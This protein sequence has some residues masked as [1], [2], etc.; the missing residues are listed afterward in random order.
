MFSARWHKLIVFIFLVAVVAH[1]RPGLAQDRA[2]RLTR[3]QLEALLAIGTPDTAVA[4]E[5]QQRG[6]AF[7]VNTAPIEDLRRKGAGTNTIRILSSMLP[8]T[9]LEIRTGVP[10]AVVMAD[11]RNLGTTDASGV[12]RTSLEAGVYEITVTAAR[13]PPTTVTVRLTGQKQHAVDVA[14]GAAVQTGTLTVRSNLADATVEGIDETAVPLGVATTLP[15]GV[16]RVQ[17]KHPCCQSFS[18]AV[19]ISAKTP[20]EVSAEF[21]GTPKEIDTLLKQA[22]TAVVAGN[23]DAAL[24]AIT[25]AELIDDTGRKPYEMLHPLLADLAPERI[26]AF[27][28]KAFERWPD[29]VF[30]RSSLG[31]ALAAAGDWL[32]ATDHL[33]AAIAAG[34]TIRLP[35]LHQRDSMLRRLRAGMI[36]PGSLEVSRTLLRFRGCEPS[37]TFEARPLDVLVRERS[38]KTGAVTLRVEQTSGAKEFAVIAST[39]DE[40]AKGRV[41]AENRVCDTSCVARTDGLL[42][43]LAA[44]SSQ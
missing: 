4:S 20:A 17:V 8:R 31:Q 7:T 11:S 14:M 23:H 3:S 36:C 10:N 41:S 18:T 15:E 13:R 32:G 44:A 21:R 25:V 42:K 9:Q 24:Q 22:L 35:M 26:A 6:V 28:L 27:A 12:L 39:A 16:Y 1:A 34:Q 33:K 38:T 40:V 2:A 30:V 37:D 5:I 43:L 19:T 29:D